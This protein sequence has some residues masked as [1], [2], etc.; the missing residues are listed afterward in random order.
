MITRV[1]T[2]KDQPKRIDAREFRM[3]P[4]ARAIA[5]TLA[6][7]GVINAAYAQQAF[8]P[9]WFAAKGA[10]QQTAAQTGKLPNGMP[11]SSLNSPDGQRQRANEQLTRSINNLNLAA[12]GIAAQQ[13]AQAAARLAAGN[14]ATDVP[15]GL[16]E[17]GLK[18]D[19]NSLTRGWLNAK[20][21]TQTVADGKTTVTIGQTADKA[22]LNWE[23]FNVGR[24]TTVNFDQATY[25]AAGNR[26]AQTN[27]AVL[28]KVNDPNAR[29]S[30]I[31]GQIKADGTV[32]ILN[33][34]GVIF[35]GTSQV[36]VRNLVAA[37]A[38]VIDTQFKDRGLYG[39]D[40]NTA[41]FTDALGK[42]E[43]RA[44]AQITT[45]EP[46]SVTQGGGYVLLA[47]TE[48]HNAG[49][50][51]TR[52]GQTQLVAGDSF[53][54]RK[55]VGSDANTFSTTRGNEVAPQFKADSTAGQVV[56]SG[57]IVS[58]EG[59]ITLAGRDV[60]QNGVAI[61]TTTV[62]TRGTVHL[63]NSASD[64]LGNVTLGKDAVTAVLI[65]DDGKTTALD[66]QRD[67]L[68]SESAKQDLLRNQTDQ[69]FFDNLSQLSDRRDQSRI[70]IV[71]GGNVVF[72]GESLTLATGGQIVTTAAKRSFVADKAQLDVA[73]AV[74][75]NV[76]MESNNVK[77]NVQGNEL[78]DSP[79]NRDSGKLFNND[80]W[81][82]RRQLILVPKGTDGYESDRWYTA[83]GLLEVGGYLSNQGHGIGEW[84]AQG[85][86]VTLTGQ[87]VIT[88]AGSSV[89]LAGGTLNVATGF[90]NQTWLKGS[91]GRL[92]SLDKAPADMTFGGLY[93]GYEANY[94]RWKVTETFVNPLIGPGKRLENGYTVGRDAGTLIVS[95]PTAILEGEIDASVYNGP[96][97]SQAR[98]GAADGYRQSQTAVAQAGGLD[99]RGSYV[100]EANRWDPSTANVIFGDVAPV[101]LDY[102]AM[103]ELPVERS[104]TILL[105]SAA[106]NG[107]GLGA[108]SVDT[109]GSIKV[110][111]ALVLHNGG[112]LVF[113][114]A[115]L[116]DIGAD[117]VVHGGTVDLAATGG[118]GL[119]SATGY[120]DADLVLRRGATI[121]TRGAWTNLLLDPAAD[122]SGL[123][124]ING[125]KVSLGATH[126]LALEAGSAIDTRAGGAWLA[127]GK[128][129]GGAG[130][131]ISLSNNLL[132]AGAASSPELPTGA[133]A[134]ALTLDGELRAA[135]FSK[136]GALSIDAAGIVVIGDNSFQFGDQL[137]TGTV[138][139][140]DVKLAG[141]L[142]V[143]AGMPLPVSTLATS[144]VMPAGSSPAP[145]D[146]V[147][148]DLVGWVMKT[149]WVNS[150]GTITYTTRDGTTYSAWQGE[151]IPAGATIISSNSTL[152][153]YGGDPWS[154]AATLPAAF[155]G[156]ALPSAQQISLP[157][158]STF[159]A[160]LSVAAG[161]VLAAGYTLPSAA[162]I[163][164]VRHQHLDTA[165]FAKGFSAY[166][167][168]GSKGLIV[169][170]G[171][172]LAPTQ[173]LLDF[174]F[175][176]RTVASG[177]DPYAALTLQTRPL[178]TESP[179]TATLTQRPGVDLTLTAG[180]VSSSASYRAGG[181][182]R[183]GQGATLEVDPGHA[184][185]LAAGGQITVEGSLI[186][187]GGTISVLN[188]RV[189]DLSDPG[190]LSIWIGSSAVLDA[191]GR[192]YTATDA[193]GRRYGTVLDGGTI[194]LGH[195]D[196]VQLEH[197]WYASTPAAII[198]R[199]DARVDASGTAAVLN[200]ANGTATTVASN[201]GEIVLSSNGGLYL[202]G[203]LQAAAGGAGASGG[204]LSVQFEAPVYVIS[205]EVP[206]RPRLQASRV[207]TVTQHD[208][209]SGL[210]AGLAPGGADATLSAP[211]AR[212]SADA[213][214]AG[215]FDT[216][217]LWGRNGIVFDGDVSLRAGLRVALLRG[218]VFGT[219]GANVALSAPYVLLSG[220]TL[221]QTGTTNYW[222]PADWTA[223]N[224]GTA[225]G[226]FN[227]QAALLDAQNDVGIGFAKTELISSG[228]LRFLRQDAKTF[229]SGTTLTTYGDLDL[230]ARQAY[231]GTS[232]VVSIVAG[233]GGA[234]DGLTI[235]NPAAGSQIR[236][237][238][239]EGD[240]PAVP[241]SVFGQIKLH[242]DS[243]LQG[244]VL[245]APL[246]SITLGG[247]AADL[248]T[249]N[250]LA[251]F[252]PGSITSV[253]AAGLTIPYGG[254]ADGVN[255]TVDGAAAAQPS[256]INGA[257]VTGTAAAT[258]GID[259]SGMQVIVDKGA[260][261]DLS[262]G[263]ELLGA[264]F[265]TGR[266][267][268]VDTLLYPRTAGNQVYALVPGA[269]TAPAAGGYY[270][271]WTG[272]VPAIGQQI[273]VP[274][275][276]P[277]LAAGTYALLPANY[278]LL[279]GAYRVE[280][281]SMQSL[282]AYPGVVATRDGSYVFSTQAGIA[283]TGIQ[284]A[285]FTGATL[286][287]A[288]VVRTWA[289]YTE[290]SYTD[291]QLAQAA[292]TGT[293]RPLLPADGKF[294]TVRLGGLGLDREPS[295]APAF[296]FAGAA[297]FEA[298][299]VRQGQNGYDGVFAITTAKGLRKVGPYNNDIVRRLVVTAEGSQ[300]LHDDYT[301]PVSAVT[302]AAVG[303]PRL[304]VGGS[305]VPSTASGSIEVYF[306]APAAF[307]G[308]VV[309]SGASL[310]AGQLGIYQPT[311]ESGSV[312]ST[313]GR[314]A[315]APNTDTGY[316]LAGTA[317][318]SDILIGGGNQNV[319][320]DGATLYADGALRF[321]GAGTI[322]IDGTPHIAAREI[323]LTAAVLNIGSAEGLAD[324]AAAGVLPEGLSL[325]QSVLDLLLAG[326]AAAGLPGA[327][328][329]TLSGT[330]SVNFFGSVD[331]DA[332]GGG[333]LEQMLLTTPALY[334][335]G[336]AGDAVRISAGRLVWQGLT[337]TTYSDGVATAHSYLPGATVEN[338]PGSG[339]GALT[340]SADE[341]V[342]GY[343]A[344]NA[345]PDSTLD[346]NRL[347]LGFSDVTLA[348]SQRIVSNNAG[349]LTVYQSGPSP[350]S[351]YDA[352]TTY[353]GNGG[354]LHLVTPLLTG[355]AGSRFTYRTGGALT[356][357]TPAGTTAGGTS[358][359]LGATL[360]LVA[361]SIDLATAVTLHSGRLT[362]AADQDITLAVGAAIDLSGLDVA[363]YDV[364]KSTW[365]GSL[366]AEST[367][368]SIVFAE[369]SSVDLSAAHEDAGMLTLTATGAAAGQVSLLGTLR[370]TGAKGHTGGS[371]DLRAQRLGNGGATLTA[372][373]AA[374]NTRLNDAGFTES[375]SFV[376]KQGNLAIGDELRAHEVTVSI[377]G[378]SLTVNGTVDA[379]GSAPGTI[380]LA[381]LGD[382]TLAG[383]AR[384]DAHG[385][386][387]QVDSYGK[388]IEAKNRGHIELTSSRGWLRLND[389]AS[390]DVS[391][392]D[393]FARGK[394][395]LN[396]GRTGE[397]SGDTRIDA[398]GTV[399]VKGAGSIALNAFWAYSPTDEAGTIVQNNGGSTPV[400]ADGS[401]G[402]DQIDT[403]NV[404]FI[405]AALAN[406]DLSART[407]G[408]RAYGNTYR[409]RPGVEINSV[410]TPSGQLTVKG[411]IDLAGYRYGP[412]AD[413][414]AASAIYGAGEPLALVI[415]AS[416]NLTVNGSLSDGFA[417]VAEIPAEY[418][419]LTTIA[420]LA[421]SYGAYYDNLLGGSAG[422]YV[423]PYSPL[424][425]TADWTVPDTAFYQ[426]M[427]SYGMYFRDTSGNVYGPGNTVPKGAQLAAYNTLYFQEGEPM[428]VLATGISP[429]Y[430]AASGV[431][432]RA[433]MLA[434]GS[435]S[436][437][438][439]LVAGADLGSADT[440]T[441]QTAKLLKQYV[442]G[443]TAYTGI[444]PDLSTSALFPGVKYD[445]DGDG[446]LDYRA[447][448]GGD[449]YLAQ[450][451]TIP[452]TP[453]TQN[454]MIVA[455][456][457][458]AP[459][460]ATYSQGQ[461]I[462]AGA[463]LLD[464]WIDGASTAFPVLAT[465]KTAVA[466]L[467][468][469][470]N[471]TLSD[472]R[473]DANANNRPGFSVIRTGTG[474]LELLAGGNLAMNSLYGVYT[475]GTNTVLASGNDAYASL[476][477]YP[478]HGGDLRVVA[479]GD[480]SGYGTYD[481]SWNT[482][483]VSNWLR[484]QSSTG[485]AW[486]V[487]FGE[488][489]NGSGD[490]Q[491]QSFSG[492]GALGGGNV[493]IVVGGDAGQLKSTTGS[494]GSGLTVAVGSTGRV[495]DGELVL[496]GGGDLTVEIGGRL[497]PGSADYYQANNGGV[498]GN[499]VN[500]RGDITLAASAIGGIQLAYGIAQA[501]DPRAVDPY[502]ATSTPRVWG[503]PAVLPGDSEV[504]IRTL[505]DLV[506]GGVGDAFMTG[507]SNGQNFSLWQPTTA[508]TLFSAG[509][510]LEPRFAS[511]VN[512][513]AITRPSTTYTY[514]MLPP[515]FRAVAA[516]G[517]IY[518][519]GGSGS[520][521]NVAGTTIELAPSAWNQL[522]LLAWDSYYS[523][524]TSVQS[525]NST[526]PLRLAVS[527][528][529]WSIVPGPLNPRTGSSP[530]G[531]FASAA[532]VPS[533]SVRAS[534]EPI[535]VYAI[536]GDVLNLLL[537]EA[538]APT[539]VT[540]ATY[541]AALPVQVRAGGDIVGF[542]VD[543]NPLGSA[544]LILNRDSS[545]VS[546]I[547]AGGD[548]WYAKVIVA[549][550]GTLEVIAGGNIYQGDKGSLTSV[551]PIVEGD[552][553][554]GASIAVQAGLGA[555][556]PHWSKLA[557]LYLN[558]ANQA[559]LTPGHPLAEQPGKV[560][561]TYQDELATWLG[562][563]YGFTGSAEEGL[564]YF[565]ALAP[566]QQRI[567]LRSVYYT[568]LKAGGREYN[569]VDGPRLGSYLR[570]R[571]MISTLFPAQNEAGKPLERG[572]NYTAFGASGIQTQFG[573]D[574]QM[575]VPAGSITVGTQ[576]TAP[577][578]S[579]GLITQG[580]GDI[581]LYSKDSI[582]LGLSRIMTTFG[583]SILGWSTEGDINA[584]RGSKTTLV[585]T[586]PKR[587]YDNV[588]N[589]TM[590]PDVPSTGAG[591]ATLN[592]LP[593]VPP[594]DVDLIAPLG[595]I[596]LGEAGVR[597]SGNVNFAALQVVNAANLQ[598]QG[599]ATG[600]P[601]VAAVNVAALTNASAA[602]SQASAAAQDVMQRERATARQALPSIFTVRVLGFG[603]ERLEPEESEKPS[604][605]K[606]PGASLQSDDER[607]DPSRPVKIVGLAERIDPKYW[608]RLTDA[609][610]Q[611]LRQDR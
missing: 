370:G 109:T 471:L 526:A 121:D 30:Q 325:N 438:I 523:G 492:F 19:T 355:D 238:A 131:D 273:T 419:G 555:T 537:G 326:D 426:E 66:S 146:Y 23:T 198:I 264:A 330:Q 86:T 106:L 147:D 516:S 115:R 297:D 307:E 560:A 296:V 20:D 313:L 260:L 360:N 43:V 558:P 302:L 435:Q 111:E 96:S 13:A 331:L 573:G 218:T 110:E 39:A 169:G 454:Y 309:E 409:L 597:V 315:T 458:G 348:A 120:V 38:T 324:A 567:F 421:S 153:L 265:V 5:M 223:T 317:Q 466:P 598:V 375:R 570:G 166:S 502:A 344:Q 201:G 343:P 368:G 571:Q 608:A 234:F 399:H 155:D 269:V 472:T 85:G 150:V 557:A 199:P 559:D 172:T 251:R 457:D 415:R 217:D 349:N 393:G 588:G 50:I 403:R 219:E 553:R 204:R 500:T 283:H 304:F 69:G 543:Q 594:G 285:L 545:D 224:Q 136:A 522:E 17:G 390:L 225:G 511:S 513:Y 138:L 334:G 205:S 396:T 564:A 383:T 173:A 329:L 252:L 508:V 445:I 424:Y 272:D 606:Q 154:T 447:G 83:N 25:D 167:I 536:N 41:T 125:G 247:I 243:I 576:G 463:L 159:T 442:P 91:D 129:R 422:Y 148:I 497:N 350:D 351:S 556:E 257:A 81:I 187:P 367:A 58:R 465:G 188:E 552:T 63:L 242:A 7:G 72:E 533:G 149:D 506:L 277:G 341:I 160:D 222:T 332:G 377:D 57:L 488:Y 221:L 456:P 395:E 530:G 605:S 562:E 441:L 6:A 133:G 268:S 484:S 498:A 112:S 440:R 514:A 420:T 90:I 189:L 510:N 434:A 44:G 416:D 2:G 494:A 433:P 55:G 287:P 450:D 541:A 579:S 342:L 88:Q 388:P 70:E 601:T 596:D 186:A 578:A 328:K 303:A 345:Q 33:R 288:E 413:R 54:I 135:G 78:R 253:S 385:S 339:S 417:S 208:D 340:I 127:G 544:S 333:K 380:R 141:S 583:G 97:Q 212:V 397:T 387:L 74:G 134:G 389:G 114:N 505:G 262:G 610:R 157:A 428:P 451:W 443:Y 52:K 76:A 444:I 228:D 236:I 311:L 373:F 237:L 203:T 113:T 202:D 261:L 100:P 404:A 356:A 216:V 532:D 190:T 152:Y 462:P 65:E 354:S 512:T 378:G 515:I 95:A 26:T 453:F 386:V 468:T 347:V 293:A 231:P 18:V 281:G 175:A 21:P 299:E 486:A 61:S 476:G 358:T 520:Q 139:P 210:A 298:A 401:V 24:N 56:N 470:G 410:D 446:V 473:T 477:Y 408:L 337:Y 394:V 102:T 336:A 430:P 357:S 534:S 478:D 197:G 215:G 376:V 12:R 292:L 361:D 525:I 245:R 524:S 46:A 15:D 87:E 352:A 249:S 168:N 586:P 80:V 519:Q 366:V 132:M 372:D 291:F 22:I 295:G 144:S 207:L 590:S 362:L 469:K 195:A 604:S 62:N 582:L 479:Q 305:I 128:T 436:A 335:H 3:A 369:G 521:G 267:G 507:S 179:A 142:R 290:T 448:F 105:N 392:P 35:D 282:N 48:V 611:S 191:A 449:L 158:G 405:D 140:I 603:N 474:K 45:H 40:A 321:W 178:H 278:A 509:G 185:R 93:K 28:N 104:G 176:S 194:V 8:S 92:Y 364:A 495:V 319:I 151:T 414:N 600:I 314:R 126:D 239:A 286:T 117:L 130:G 42:I 551:G 89:N 496:T 254:T 118:A 561:H 213:I 481:N 34:N 595:T 270:S 593:E 493:H 77:V 182:L 192:A 359:A 365:G 427:L 306:A 200:R 301:I 256:A 452:V 460:G 547:Q 569:D 538:I 402:L 47:G 163:E 425:V 599:Q 412:Q 437:S 116:I 485:T 501:G 310:S 32:M 4:I 475:V 53:I 60:Q 320:H 312:L 108:L 592:P 280:L 29:P 589:V 480:L 338:G 164:R 145:E 183:I 327:E 431:S 31:Q 259:A 323:G 391:A 248:E 274:A 124:W 563:R 181:W 241:Y 418:S 363:F 258:R 439:R 84:A 27:W 550:P 271:K 549:G 467:Y 156:I 49:E 407:A 107:W 209:G 233:A 211:H 381:A 177:G 103:A 263:G 64:A 165:L 232:A 73:G 587:V 250:A 137:V 214:E 602:A 529:N 255:Y 535:R 275:G 227:M 322:N 94:A 482:Y 429:A 11:A 574:I 371:I 10:V 455:L 37:A 36:N 591:I 229:S 79:L 531:Y 193:L 489:V 170:D 379:S 244:G 374:L 123:A 581:S 226:T 316:L 398:S 353:A 346:F 554:P 548:I 220:E 68:I 568:E 171:V 14:A 16:G 1:R 503:G 294:L 308:V 575:L 504:A 423:Y 585:Y 75:V 406:G 584:G 82:D 542:G 565:N 566:E 527:G 459:F 318:A 71:S 528:A 540:P 572:G 230:T 539:S 246:G 9:S 499:F 577:P 143:P 464:G 607:Y 119:V 384:L 99:L 122:A 67:G 180:D 517:S 101:A 300:T 266:G 400:G 490:A 206:S 609:E 174:D 51:T 276:V 196:D 483:S 284:D 411:D 235:A 491:L 461:T 289:H 279:P 382:F 432:V 162:T 580:E 161:T 184:I 98:A 487:N 59:D 546:L 518:T 240:T